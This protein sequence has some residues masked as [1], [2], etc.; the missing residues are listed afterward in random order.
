MFNFVR[1]LLAGFI[2]FSS[3]VFA[4]DYYWT[5]GNTGNQQ[6]SDISTACDAAASAIGST[7]SYSIT[8]DQ[9]VPT[10]VTS[11]RCKFLRDGKPNLIS[12]PYLR[13]GNS[14]P[15]GTEEDPETGECVP[16]P[17]Q[18]D[19]GMTYSNAFPATRFGNFYVPNAP[20]SVCINSCAYG[21][22]SGG[23]GGCFPTASGTY[24]VANFMSN[25]EE[26]GG[27]TDFPPPPD[28]DDPDPDDPNDYSNCQRRM[29][30][31]GSYMWDCNPS[32]DQG[33]CPDGFLIGNDGSTCYRDPNVPPP[34]DPGDGDGSGD[35]DGDGD[36]DGSGDGSGNHP[37]D[38]SKDSTLKSIDGKI[39]TSNTLLQGI[40]DA[41]GNIPG[42]GGG[43]GN[44][45][46]DG[47][48][49]PESTAS[50][51]NCT[52]ELE[53]T[54]DAV[55]CATLKI[56]KDQLCQFELTAQV[57]QEVKA[58]FEGEENQLETEEI[59]FESLFSDG[60]NAGRWLPSTCPSP[61]S[62]TVMGR[63]Y[64]FSW[65]PLCRFATA[66]SGLIVAMAS[67]FFV[68]FIGKGLKGS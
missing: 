30:A 65:E 19:S 21:Q 5:T 39:G 13:N 63:T 31:D 43:S 36:G 12:S 51:L 18:C 47:D 15:E 22:Y 55:Q 9:I 64:S 57:E 2:L 23:G 11:G 44:G 52:Q 60:L 1:V 10:S 16:P 37:P 46:D 56:Q 67:I 32:A 26:C 17:P 25:G 8:L 7:S 38:Y 66:L 42:G 45:S 40:K 49:E 27:N 6:F 61:E 20:A 34:K 68:V 3:S 48:E 54:G 4:V 50:G 62:F 28:P 33:D 35:G 58:V 24:C 41:I 53:C 59:A 14:C 29:Q